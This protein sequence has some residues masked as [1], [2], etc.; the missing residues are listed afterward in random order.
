M[1]NSTPVDYILRRY[2]PSV[3]RIALLAINYRTPIEFEDIHFDIWDK[4]INGLSLV[5]DELSKTK[6]KEE[7]RTEYGLFEPYLERFMRAMN[8]DMNVPCAIDVMFSFVD[9]VR[10]KINDRNLS[11]NNAQQAYSLLHQFNHILG[12]GH[13]N[14]G[15]NDGK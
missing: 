7:I 9:E 1:D 13:F 10:T 12:L 2:R 3:L 14:K 6:I 4:R 15:D 11:N 5:V 8:D